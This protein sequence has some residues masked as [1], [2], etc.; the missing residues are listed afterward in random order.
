MFMP[1]P[2]RSAL[3]CSLVFAFLA[4][5]FDG[6]SHALAA[7]D[8]Q[9][10]LD[11]AFEA[12]LKDID[13]RAGAVRDFAARFE[14]KK[15][16]ALLRKPLVSSGVVRVVG[17]TVRW[18]TERPEPAVLH[19]D[20]KEVRLY[21]P[22]QKL[23]EAYPIDKRMSDLA[24]SPLPRLDALKQSFAFEPLPPAE[25]KP[26]VGDLTEGPDRLAVRLKPT[27]GFLKQHVAEVRVLLDARTGLMLC[28]VTVDVEGDR[29]VIRFSDARTNA[30]LKPADVAFNPPADVK[31]SR[32]LD[33]ASGK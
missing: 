24:A 31:I 25:L 7:P 17:G 8:S 16:T 20:A 27:G 5:P 2:I 32:P 9:P 21:Y 18:D 12:R 14:Q 11:P 29:T 1:H 4:L 13:A 23:V 33:A 30:G 22:K 6:A 15:Y 3:V 19:A 10:A 28:V 26:D